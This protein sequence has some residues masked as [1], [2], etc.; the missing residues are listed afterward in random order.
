MKSKT[1]LLLR[2]FLSIFLLVSF[3]IQTQAQEICDN[4]IDDDGDFLIDCFD[5]D[6]AC[7]ICNNKQGN[8]WYFGDD[9]NNTLG[10]PGGLF[11]NFNQMNGGYPTVN[12]ST[13]SGNTDSQEGS[14]TISDANGNLL[15]Y[16]D[17]S[18][19]VGGQ[20]TIITNGSNTLLGGNSSTHA[21]VIVPHPGNPAQFYIFTTGESSSAPSS[22]VGNMYSLITFS[23]SQPSN[24]LEGIINPLNVTTNLL[25]YSEST[26]KLAVARHANC[27]DYWLITHDY[28]ANTGGTTGRNYVT[29]PI[30]ASGIGAKTNHLQTQSHAGANFKKRGQI[31]VSMDNSKIAAAVVG[32]S[33]NEI[34]FV[35]IT[36]FNNQTGQ[37]TP[38]LVLNMGLTETYGTAFSPSGQYLYVTR[39]AFL[40]NSIPEL[41]RYDLYASNVPA[42]QTLMPTSS[43]G[44]AFLGQIKIGPDGA[45]YIA[46]SGLGVL[47]IPNPDAPTISTINLIANNLVRLGLPYTIPNFCSGPRVTATATPPSIC[48]GQSSVIQATTTGGAGNSTNDF[49]YIWSNGNTTAGFNVFPNG[50]TNYAVT[51]SDYYGCTS[52]DNTTVSVSGLGVTSIFN[53]EDAAGIQKTTF[54]CGEDVYMDGTAS[55]NETNHY[56]DVWE[57]VNG[58]LVYVGALGWQGGPVTGPLNLSLYF[59]FVPGK[60]YQVKLAV[61]NMPCVGWVET[62]HQFTVAIPTGDANFNFTFSGTTQQGLAIVNL[63]GNSNT[64]SMEHSWEVF[65]LTGVG[66]SVITPA[67][68]TVGWNNAST[69]TINLASGSYSIIHHIRNI[70]CN[71]YETHAREI[72]LYWKNAGQKATLIENAINEQIETATSLQVYPNPSSGQINIKIDAAGSTEGRLAIYDMQGR[73]LRTIAEGNLTTEVYNY[74]F[75]QEPAGVYMIQLISK[76]GTYNQKVV[77]T[78]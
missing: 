57:V 62:V 61:Q 22:Q 76:E 67:V 13:N 3:S 35:E 24:Q 60:T 29:Y 68:L 75:E 39:K 10:V 52:T 9:Y 44:N 37:I 78:K 36:N 28:S 70:D 43:F 41:L 4:G 27:K 72:G 21:A 23:A 12:S 16:T 73:L 5:P 50:T 71:V 7:Y 58:N 2:G 30:T 38:S 65:R 40:G 15:F 25:P 55:Q 77:V 69:A 8:Y 46:A 26:E 54:Q 47:Q 33:I 6:C 45:L 59:N 63:A 34:G 19:V 31:T 17:G 49:S 14:A 1:F 64:L 66:G 56:I 20:N 53:F 32:N 42:S 74:N 18:S 11:F 51:V 48:A